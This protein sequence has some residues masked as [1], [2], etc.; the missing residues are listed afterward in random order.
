M[1]KKILLLIPLFS[2]LAFS[3]PE[4]K[5]ETFNRYNLTLLKKASSP[6]AINLVSL[7]DINPL[8]LSKGI[9]FTFKNRKA[10]IVKIAGSFSRWKDIKM[11]RNKNGV[12]YYFLEEPENKVIK[13]KFIVN[14]IWS[15]DPS[16]EIKEN[17]N[18]GSYYSLAKPIQSEIGTRL[19]YIQKKK[20]YIEFRLYK[21]TAKFISIVG[22]FN[23]WNPENDILQK[24]HNGI[25]TLTKRIPKGQYR[26]KYIVDGKWETDLYNNN[27]NS[28]DD[29]GE[30]CS[31]I[32]IR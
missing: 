18:A 22:D 12:W 23:H 16:N 24:D 32:T 8:K 9:L 17:D 25:W 28:S 10:E 14:G 3:P 7:N 15:I 2:I 29:S 11:N 1:I 20:N 21:P 19:T 27:P 30:V 31:T 13:Y 5:L 26:Y 4:K 6:K